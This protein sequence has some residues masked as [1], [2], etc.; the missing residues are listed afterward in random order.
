MK[1][2]LIIQNTFFFVEKGKQ[3]W[4]P[5]YLSANTVGVSVRPLFH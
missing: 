1:Y 5:G 3:A 2:G 4:V